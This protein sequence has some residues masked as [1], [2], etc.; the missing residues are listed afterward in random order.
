MRFHSVATKHNALRDVA[1]VHIDEE[2]CDMAVF[3]AASQSKF[4]PHQ[5]IYEFSAS[6]LRLQS[7]WTVLMRFHCIA[8]EYYGPLEAAHAHMD[9]DR[10]D[11]VE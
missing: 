6:L 8:N 1:L 11:M 10:H 7:V 4:G 2:K 3:T 9:D 5:A